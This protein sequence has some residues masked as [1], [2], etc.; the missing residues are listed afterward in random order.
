[1]VIEQPD[2]LVIGGGAAGVIAAL[3]ASKN[4]KV[5]MI[6]KDRVLG[7]ASIQASGGVCLPSID[8]DVDEEIELF[9]ADTL[10]GGEDINNVDLVRLLAQEGTS[11]ISYLEELGV[12]FDR[13]MEGNYRVKTKFTEGHSVKRNYQDRRMY[14]E[15]AR[16]M[17]NKLIHSDVTLCEYTMVFGLCAENGQVIGAIAYSIP[18]GKLL[19]IMP[20]VVVLASGGYGQLYKITDNAFSLTGE[21]ASLA[22]DCGAELIDMEMVQFIPLAFPYP[23]SMLGV[24]IGMCSN[25]GPEVKLYNGLGERF[26]ERYIPGKL[27][28]GTRDEV[29]R[30]IF[31]EISEGRGTKHN[32]V[33]VDTTENDPALN[34][35]YRVSNY[36]VYS[37][38]ARVFGEKVAAWEEPFE[39]VPSQHFSMG[40][41]RI[42]TE[43]RTRCNNLFAVGE[44]S[45]GIH[46]AN[47]LAGTA[48]LEVII[49]GKI[50]GLSAG[51][52]ALKMKF[53][54][55]AEQKLKE[56]FYS[57]EAKLK[58]LFEPLKEESVSGE[59]I[60]QKIQKIMWE[61]GGIV[62]NE[63]M[64]NT[65]IS[66]IRNIAT[67]LDTLKVVDK[68]TWN[69]SLIEA[70]EAKHMVVVAEAVLKSALLR[71][72][73]RGSHYRDDYP[74][75]NEEYNG[76]V[77]VSKT[78][79]GDLTA[80]F[81]KK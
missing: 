79:E 63:H 54:P 66:E 13:D 26:M 32:A 73:S 50:A 71:K 67:Q 2:V 53:P 27:E 70:L 37:M 19:Y 40:G 41:V 42:N 80:T 75:R 5:M 1:M 20:R 68:K 17:R 21:G 28:F 62:R 58:A 22:L 74:D 33:V 7:G 15:I 55:N 46:G 11:Y 39:A 49:M 12:V 38:L 47:R 8:G 9:I 30:A 31:R 77:I 64:L 78:L 44:V 35:F 24:F 3:E 57:E 52:E 61:C 59:Q 60:K 6:A 65:G 81:E 25:F 4:A 69:Y 56:Y 51:E 34:S 36:T 72:E 43:T 18:D 29:A 23:K 48:L 76:N 14:H 16:V 10:K 45:G